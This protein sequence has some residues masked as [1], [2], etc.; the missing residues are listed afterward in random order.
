MENAMPVTISCKFKVGDIVIIPT[1]WDESK[2]YI[3]LSCTDNSTKIMSAT[4]R[5]SCIYTVKRISDNLI[6]IEPEEYF[7]LDK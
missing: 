1:E 4:K 3:V 7:E 5:V 6:M 2:K